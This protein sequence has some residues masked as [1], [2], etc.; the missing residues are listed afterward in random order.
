M[1]E[2]ITGVIRNI[3]G[4]IRNITGVIRCNPRRTTK[5]R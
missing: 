1:F 3:T 4:V 5:Q 2:D